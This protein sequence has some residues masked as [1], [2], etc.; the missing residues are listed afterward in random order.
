ME[1]SYNIIKLGEYLSNYQ[2]KSKTYTA[3]PLISA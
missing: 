3:S 1:C 2:T